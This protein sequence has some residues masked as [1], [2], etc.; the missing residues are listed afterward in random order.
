M[1]GTTQ[2]AVPDLPSAVEKKFADLIL[3]LL[4]LP[5][6]TSRVMTTS[7]CTLTHSELVWKY[8]PL[9][10]VLSYSLAVGSTLI[11]VA[12]GALAFWRNGYGAEANFSTFLAM[13]RE[14]ESGNQVIVG[15]CSLGR[16]PLSEEYV[17]KRVRFE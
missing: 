7:P 17:N 6:L 5:T 4:A 13:M 9:F 12:L 10:L 1:N 3:S 11:A 8:K 15:Q 2:F 14:V 16:A